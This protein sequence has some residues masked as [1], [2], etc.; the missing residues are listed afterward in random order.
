MA[1]DHPYLA[2]LV[3]A[4]VVSIPWAVVHGPVALEW[5]VFQALGA[6]VIPSVAGWVTLWRTGGRLKAGLWGA[7]WAAAVVFGVLLASRG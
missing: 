4:W 5:V 1:Q 7:G 6:A 2:V 3:F